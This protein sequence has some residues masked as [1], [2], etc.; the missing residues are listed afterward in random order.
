MVMMWQTDRHL[1]AV[2]PE[3]YGAVHAIPRRQAAREVGIA[4][5]AHD[6]M[7][8]AMQPRRDDEKTQHALDAAGK[9]HV[10]MMEQ[11]LGE[12]ETRN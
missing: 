4:F 7:M 2:E 1:I 6:G 8:N 3:P 9:T 10:R 12:R 5:F 11:Y